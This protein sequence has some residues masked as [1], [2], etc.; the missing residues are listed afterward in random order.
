MVEQYEDKMQL[1][2]SIDKHEIGPKRRHIIHEKVL[3][4]ENQ[5]Q[6]FYH[7]HQLLVELQ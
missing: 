1:H 4:E 7:P 3:I 5:H 2:L 6:A